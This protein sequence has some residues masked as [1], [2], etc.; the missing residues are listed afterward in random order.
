MR[1]RGTLTLLAI[2]A[3]LCGAY[4]WLSS[5]QKRT[6]QAEQE[7][8]R[9]FSFDAEDVKQIR[10]QRRG[11][12]AMAAARR[13]E[14]GWRITDPDAAILAN[15]VV[16]ERAAGALAHL[17]AARS[18]EVGPDDLAKYG[19]ESPILTVEGSTEKGEEVRVIFG[20]IEPTRTYCYARASDSTV[21]LAS[22][23]DF[24]ELNRSPLV[25]RDRGL[26]NLGEDGISRVE[27]AYYWQSRAEADDAA[28][29]GQ[30][31]PGVGEESI[32]FVLAKESDG[33]WYVAEPFHA[34]AVQE[35]ADALVRKLESAQGRGYID[36]PQSL[37]VYGLDPPRARATVTVAGGAPQTVYLG[38]LTDEEEKDSA[39]YIRRADAP[40]VFL[41]DSGL[42]ALFPN[43][44]GDFREKRL[45][46]HRSEEITGIRYVDD[47]LDIRMLRSAA[48]GE[49]A[50][51]PRGWKRPLW[52]PFL[53]TLPEELLHRSD[54][55][56]AAAGGLGSAQLLLGVSVANDGPLFVRDGIPLGTGHALADDPWLIPTM[57]VR[58]STDLYAADGWGGTAGRIELE[59]HD[60]DPRKAVSIY[61]GRKGPHES[62][63]RGVSLLSPRAEWRVGFDFDE[64]LDNESYNWVDNAEKP[65]GDVTGHAKIRSSHFELT[66]RIDD[67]SR[68]T[69][70]YRTGRKTRD[71][72]PVWN[73]E[74][75]EIWEQGIGVRS[76]GAH[77][78]WRWD[79]SWFWNDRDVKWGTD[80]AFAAGS[81]DLRLIETGREGGS[82]EMTRATALGRIGLQ[83]RIENWELQ[84][85]GGD[86]FEQ[87][88]AQLRGEGQRGRTG[89][90]WRRAVPGAARI[91]AQ[92]GMNWDS[93]LTPATDWQVR[94][95]ARGRRDAAS[96]VQVPRS[97]WELGIAGDG[98][99]PRSD[100]WLTPVLRSIAGQN[101][102]LHP[103][104]GLT[105][106]KQQRA[107][108]ELNH[109]LPGIDV[110]VQAGWTR[111]R[112]GITWAATETGAGAWTN[113]LEMDATRISVGAR[114]QGELWGVYRIGV[115]STWQSFDEK[116]AVAAALPPERFDRLHVLW[117]I[118]CS[119]KTACWR[120][121]GGRRGAGRWT[122]RGM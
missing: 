47:D 55:I 105:R 76:E 1:P 30:S 78:P 32:P 68:V 99:A 81:G 66:R 88:A 121:D 103:N 17:S 23:E 24:F 22:Y 59:R 15:S 119:R 111:L 73:V 113:G 101:L 115:Q 100:E 33:R 27:I 89:A 57:G 42:V 39:V 10:I 54:Y 53:G 14:G 96:A 11:E 25:L 116:A 19:L 37:D 43:A 58:P 52:D 69:L 122:I 61:R 104:P 91:E 87:A 64:S 34:L 63:L 120:W 85:T 72:L 74:Q 86:G 28:S 31:Q 3:L 118:T 35:K 9:L 114:R 16:W 67:R 92:G 7:A 51:G 82:A 94:L 80:A 26:I 79:S 38:I 36:A 97:G 8:K 49:E 2:L 6:E 21:F 62:Y 40:A 12:R 93:R 90:V 41:V 70:H 106:E 110:A 46:T 95:S 83:A 13:E 60:P 84:D 108:F 18:V 107:W 102:E 109:R 77:G 45:L 5:S 98:R 65:V 71:E 4:A 48:P 50:T 75:Q 29:D 117:R 56:P 44:P 20:D 112:D